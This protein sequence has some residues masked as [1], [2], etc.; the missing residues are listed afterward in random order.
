MDSSAI[1]LLSDSVYVSSFHH[2]TAIFER[3]SLGPHPWLPSPNLSRQSH[4]Y[5]TQERCKDHRQA[6]A[7]DDGGSARHSIN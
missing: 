3:G 6:C 4:V 2:F 5:S 7:A 1:L